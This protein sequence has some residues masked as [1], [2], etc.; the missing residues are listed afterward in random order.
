MATAEEIKVVIK[1]RTKAYRVFNKVFHKI[2]HLVATPNSPHTEKILE[3]EFTDLV[4]KFAD[5][6]ATHEELIDLH[7]E[8][9]GGD[10][11]VWCFPCQGSTYSMHSMASD[12]F[13]SLDCYL[14]SMS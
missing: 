11:Q 3:A 14:V 7:D 12:E 5:L 1:S 9:E 6:E 4:D 8:Y 10:F 13:L 2:D